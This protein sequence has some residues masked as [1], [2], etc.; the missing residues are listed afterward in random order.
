MVKILESAACKCLHQG[1]INLVIQTNSVDPNYAGPDLVP[2]DDTKRQRV[3]DILPYIKRKALRS[4]VKYIILT[5][6]QT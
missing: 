6:P 2:A 4:L 5:T 3:T 1:L